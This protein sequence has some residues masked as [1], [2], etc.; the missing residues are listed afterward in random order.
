MR[1]THIMIPFDRELLPGASNAINVCLRLQKSERIT[2]IT[3]VETLEVAAALSSAAHT[4]GAEVSSFVLEDH[5]T[6]PM[7]A[8]PEIVIADLARSQ[9]SI[10]AARAQSGEL[11]A[12]VQLTHAVQRHRL[13]H[14]HMVNISKQIML[15]G[16]RADFAAMDR[17]S[18]R[19][20]ERA[21]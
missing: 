17:L 6:R 14:G 1:T 15:D 11:P 7:T 9:V 4:V 12:R 13:R 16:M 10:F 2:V 19:L 5:S 20:I 8:L 3:D 21:R 18:A